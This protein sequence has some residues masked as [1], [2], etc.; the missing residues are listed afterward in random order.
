MAKI[1]Y[2][3]NI[4]LK[5]Y[6][7]VLLN[8]SVPVETM[9]L[10]GS[11]AKGTFHEWSDIDLAIVS[12]IFEGERIKDKNK[13]RHLTLSV[14]SDLEV[15]PYNPNTFINEDPFVYEILTTGIKVF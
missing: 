12:S 15:F 10:F 8:N 14:S 7:K 11:Y 3:I 9:I 6:L 5:E 1:P 13:I 4:I 2:K